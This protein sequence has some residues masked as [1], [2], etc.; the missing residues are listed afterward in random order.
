MKSKAPRLWRKRRG[1]GGKYYGSWLATIA[2]EDVNLNTTSADVA[3]KRL[4]AALR[5][6][7]DFPSDAELA[8]AASEPS[9]AGA[10][11]SDTRPSVAEG[12]TPM[13][14]AAPSAP[15]IEGELISPGGPPLL[16]S[17]V[18]ANDNARAEADAT[19]AAAAE[20][21]P[22]AGDAPDPEAPAMAPDV[23]EGLLRT[24]GDNMVELQ[25]GLQAW[26]IKKR[27][28]KEA[29]LVPP[30]SPIRSMA[31]QAWAAQF[32]K[33]FPD[34]DNTL[35]WVLAV[36]L[37]LLCVPMQVATAKEPDKKPENAEKAAA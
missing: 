25:L 21:S 34:I 13:G 2:G 37:P 11:A 20:T 12:T 15:V 1:R 32:K 9:V 27:T 36:G 17:S 23:L 35:P 26:G 8:A 29:G 3:S 18:P 7:R 4:P 6:K 24:I 31:A 14:A 28:G 19:N 30:D 33:W 16:L 5:G 22:P 10:A